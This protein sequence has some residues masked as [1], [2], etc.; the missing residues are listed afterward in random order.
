MPLYEL[1]AIAKPRLGNAALGD[2][3]RAFS[4]VVLDQVRRWVAWQGSSWA[5][6]GGSSPPCMMGPAGLA[7]EPCSTT[8]RLLLAQGGVIT[9]LKSFGE[10]RLAYDIRKRGE[11]HN[12]VRSCP[13]VWG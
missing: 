3:M 13:W 1:F 7:P 9:D 12:E 2:M 8:A 11:R 5:R 6:S 10:R 4:R